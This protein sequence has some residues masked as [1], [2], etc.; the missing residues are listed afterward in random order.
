MKILCIIPA[1]GGSK[2]IPR[3]NIKPLLGKPLIVYTIEAALKSRLIDRVIVSTDDSEIAEIS[4]KYG[5]EAPFERPEEASTDTA[6]AVD[7]IVHALDWL[8]ENENYLPDAVIYLQ[9]TSPLRTVKHIDE[10]ITIFTDDPDA[11]SLVSVIKP[12]HNFNPVKLMKLEGK[13]LVPYLEGQGTVVLDRHNIP[14]VYAR[15]GPVIVIT[16]A[17]IILKTKQLYGKNILPYFMDAD[18]SIDIDEPKDLELAE[19]Y[20]VSSTSKRDT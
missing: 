11:E 8:R 15:N 16:K 9:P 6:P 2:G 1:R 7:V 14:E 5:A 4:K 18:S 17:D 20:M 12:P 10:A 13:Y 3:K 19:F